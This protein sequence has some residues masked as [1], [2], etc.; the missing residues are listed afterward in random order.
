[1]AVAVD[2]TGTLLHTVSPASPINQ[3][4]GLTVG[5]SANY[6]VIWIVF[7]LNGA[8]PVL[9][10]HWNGAGG[11]LMTAVGSITNA[12]GFV[13]ATMYEL[14]APTSGLNNFTLSWTNLIGEIYVFGQSY[15]GVDQTTP[16]NGL[17]TVSATIA[18]NGTTALP[19]ITSAVGN[20]VVANFGD[21]F[22]WATINQTSLFLNNGTGIA[23]AGNR[24]AGAASVTMSCTQTSGSTLNYAAMGFNINASAASS[25][26]PFVNSNWSVP[27]A[28]KRSIA[29][30]FVRNPSQFPN[31][32]PFNSFDQNRQRFLQPKLLDASKATNLNLFKNPIPFN[33]TSWP[34]PETIY[35]LPQGQQPYNDALYSVVVTAPF[36]QTNW[37]IPSL[38]KLNQPQINYNNVLYATPF[39]QNVRAI[40]EI[41][42]AALSI[43]YPNLV[44]NQPV[45]GI[46][47]NQLN[48]PKASAVPQASFDIYNIMIVSAPAD[49][50]FAQYDWPKAKSISI[51]LDVKFP[52]IVLNSQVVANNP[53]YL[54][55]WSET[56]LLYSA[57]S[58]LMAFNINLFTNP[59]PFAQYN[60][61]NSSIIESVSLNQ[62]P[63]NLNLY[64]ALTPFVPINWAKSFVPIV[65]QSQPLSYN[66]N[67]Y[68]V[69][70]TSVPFNQQNWPLVQQVKIA[71]SFTNQNFIPLS[72]FIF[73]PAP[74][75]QLN[76]PITLLV[77]KSKIETPLGSYEDLLNSVTPVIPSVDVSF[78]PNNP[79]VADSGG[80]AGKT[81]Q[82]ERRE[83]KVTYAK[84]IHEHKI[85][86][87]EYK[88]NK[89]LKKAKKV[90]KI[91]SDVKTLLELIAV[92]KVKTNVKLTFKK[93]RPEPILKRPEPILTKSKKID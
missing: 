72:T 80:G 82:Q 15:T 31:P 38:P 47:F 37:P 69:I 67:L 92:Q 35:G 11:Q 60:W 76:W 42:Q 12:A 2:A 25:T 66:L 7:E 85:Y 68:G 13:V 29:I 65:A 4:I 79:V 19:A 36:Y 84:S 41:P 34:T 40:S 30:D 18:N 23:T 86:K 93:V 59:I 8:A 77:N 55:D 64:A 24:A 9:T 71:S 74:F 17:Q 53:F 62:I 87:L 10:V 56:K 73:V 75:N 33:K 26:S 48:W 6:L 83:I 43:N 27:N 1:M 89:K 90:K 81:R 91:N 54:Q 78:R 16:S 44:I 51:S 63:Y 61:V 32:I 46:P 28:I 52:N 88:K 50:P 21:D 14:K 22:S 20:M 57:S 49:I 3:T 58:S 5:A 70:D 45:A 39:L